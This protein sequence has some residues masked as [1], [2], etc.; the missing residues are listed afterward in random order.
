MT[1]VIAMNYLVI[2]L[3]PMAQQ[4]LD[5][6]GLLLIEASRSNSDTSHSVGLLW[7]NDQLDAGT[8]N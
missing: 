7:T 3:S 6:Q 2:S 5:G 4:P 8:S 1:T